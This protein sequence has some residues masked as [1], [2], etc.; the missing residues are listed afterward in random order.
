VLLE[1]SVQDARDATNR[2]HHDK[3]LPSYFVLS[4]HEALQQSQILYLE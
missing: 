2:K 1:Q 3:V 4:N